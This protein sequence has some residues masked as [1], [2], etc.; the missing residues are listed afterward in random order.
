MAT[1]S[2]ILA[3]RLP[4][5]EETG[6]SPRGRKGSDT[7]ERPSTRVWNGVFGVS[8]CTRC[9]LISWI[10]RRW[11]R[12][13]RRGAWEA[14]TTERILCRP[15]ARAPYQLIWKLWVYILT[16]NMAKLSC[17]NWFIPRWNPWRASRPQTVLSP[18]GAHA[19]FRSE[20]GRIT[21]LPKRLLKC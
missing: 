10:V 20:L 1:H 5:T 6:Y 7:N 11:G 9:Y 17:T 4:W 8:W 12:G 3:W 13:P 14:G 15:W 21:S 18:S 2:S 19:L 16:T